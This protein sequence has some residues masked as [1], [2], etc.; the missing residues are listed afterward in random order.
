MKNMSK[1]TKSSLITYGLVVLAYVVAE[2]FMKTG[3]MTSLLKGLL[4]PLC[5]YAILAVSL[6][7]TVGILGEL[8]LGHAGFM[9]V[10]AFTSAVFTK[11][12][13]HTI[14][15]PTVR[16]LLALLV[17]VVCAGICGVLIGIPVLRLRGDYLA[18]VTLAFG[19][20][21]KNLVNVIYLGKDSDCEFQQIHFRPETFANVILDN[22]GIYPI[23]MMHAIHFHF[24]TYYHQKSDSVLDDCLQKVIDLHASSDS[25]FSAANINLALMNIML[26]ILDKKQPDHHFVD[27][28]IQNSYVAYTLDHIHKNY[29]YKIHQEDI[30]KELQ[31]SVRYLSTLFKKYMNITLSNYI[32]IYRINKSIEL[33]QSDKSLTEIA[34]LVGFKDSQHYSKLFMT[35][36]GE[37]PS[38]YRKSYIKDYY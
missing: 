29:M 27:P 4:V 33:M 37:T 23:S 5:V 12:M 8:S 26:H 32:N 9:C 2:I 30:A 16:F 18:I 1:T 13:M 10:G 20:I 3:H 15:V 25:L 34:Q 28:N 21:I 7:L 35:I 17:G 24:K 38:S 19:E 31:I 11:C 36:I 14:T 22:S 6:N